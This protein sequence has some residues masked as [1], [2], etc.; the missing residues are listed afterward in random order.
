MVCS[1]TFGHECFKLVINIIQA[2]DLENHRGDTFPKFR[3]VT[4]QNIQPGEYFH[5]E[6]ETFN[7][8]DG[9]VNNNGKTT[10][11]RLLN[12]TDSQNIIFAFR[13]FLGLETGILSYNSSGSWLFGR[14]SLHWYCTLPQC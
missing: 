11:V 2:N 3:Y 1:G 10:D 6:I 9:V 12:K 8:G 4:N 14:Q 7:V 13:H 5:Y